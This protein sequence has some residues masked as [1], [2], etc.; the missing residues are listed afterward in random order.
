MQFSEGIFDF[1]D[2]F[3][4]SI[5][6]IVKGDS[7]DMSS[8]PFAVGHEDIDSPGGGD[9][10][11]KHHLKLPLPRDRA[12]LKEFNLLLALLPLLI[13]P[14]MHPCPKFDIRVAVG[15]AP[16][17]WQ[18]LHRFSFPHPVMRPALDYNIRFG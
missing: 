13:L 14:I 3:A 8:E 6:A 7:K 16:T 11:S 9:I 10:R 18:Y 1:R 5:T 12:V 15:D 4:P 2:K 17:V